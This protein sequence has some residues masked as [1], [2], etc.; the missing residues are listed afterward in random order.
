MFAAANRPGF[1]DRMKLDHI[2]NKVEHRVLVTGAAGFVGVAVVESLLKQGFGKIRCFTRSRSSVAKIDELI[3]RYGHQ[4]Q[5]EVMSGNLLAREDCVKAVQE[6]AVIYHLAAA[7]GL[8]SIPHAFLNSVVTTRN[9][10][11]AALRTGCLKR[12]VN[13]SSFAVYTNTHKP[14]GRI[15]DEACPVETSPELRG[16]AYSFSK[17]KQDEIVIEYGKTHNLPYVLLRPGVVYGPGKAAISQRVGIGTFGIFLHL[18]GSNQIPLTYIDNCAD[19]TV[20]AGIVPGIDG[21]V[22]NIV[23]DDLPS[24]RQFLRA[25]KQNVKKFR[26]ILLPKSISFL[27][28]YGWEKYSERS[29][30]QLPQAYNL[31]I[32]NANWKSTRYTNEKLKS[33]LG[34]SPRVT[35]EDGLQ[36]FFAACKNGGTHA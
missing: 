23:D 31:K 12:F 21:E 34:W 13:M 15:L 24:S 7:T 10:M 11:E 22:F 2:I 19:A 27:L 5:I 4:A 14:R 32:W 18:G 35:T 28:C 33:R 8:K 9:L 6:V 36:Q 25:Y 20:R 16:D 17:V 30:G 3:R 26:S 29:Q 1:S